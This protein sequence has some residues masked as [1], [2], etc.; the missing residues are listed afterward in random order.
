M[1]LFDHAPE[2]KIRY[3]IVGLGDIA[4]EAMLPGVGH[5][6][7]SEVTAFVTGDAVKARELR[8]RYNVEHAFRYDQFDELLDAD[9]VDAI[10]LA[11]PN[12]RH[13][14]FA[15]PALKKG[16]HVLLEK[17]MEVSTAKCQEILDAQKETGAKL[18]IAYRLHFEPATLSTIDLIRKGELGDLRI[19]N[20][21]FAQ[22]V[23]PANHRA[24]NGVEGGPLF[25]MGTY[26]INAAR[27][28][29]GEEPTEVVAAATSR[30]PD[31]GL[32]DL[33]DTVSATLRFSGGRLAH[34]VVSYAASAIDAFTV[35]GTKG[36]LEMNPAF[37]FGKSLEQFVRIDEKDTH[38]VHKS[39]DQFGGE[40]R[41]FSDCILKNENPEPDGEEGYA[42]VRVIEAIL[43]TLETGRA[44]KLEPFVRARRIDPDKQEQRMNPKSAPKPVHAASPTRA[45]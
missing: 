7:N 21:T 23:D 10:Y 32:G 25:D 40:M 22:M 5:T 41:Y 13:A 31:A 27:Y 14:E 43:R 44:Q 1:G 17:P 26:P 18:M 3:A 28:V 35:V 20:A 34:F 24:N 2:K 6:G 42:D 12:W 30:N 33:D 11:T 16:I 15:V 36:S 45:H 29:F 8:D 39:T 38:Y 4:Q 9:L 19:F 37:G